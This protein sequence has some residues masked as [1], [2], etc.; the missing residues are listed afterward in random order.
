[1][2]LDPAKVVANPGENGLIMPS[3]IRKAES[4]ELIAKL[5]REQEGTREEVLR[6]IAQAESDVFITREKWGLRLVWDSEREEISKLVG[7][8]IE[9][10]DLQSPK[11]ELIIPEETILQIPENHSS[12]S[13]ETMTQKELEMYCNRYFSDPQARRYILSLF[14]REKDF[15]EQ[16]LQINL[17]N[18]YQQDETETE[19]NV[20]TLWTTELRDPIM[21]RIKRKLSWERKRIFEY[22]YSYN[23]VQKMHKNTFGNVFIMRLGKTILWQIGMRK[24]QIIDFPD[25]YIQRW[26][27]KNDEYSSKD[28]KLP[29]D[30]WELCERA[31][32]ALGIELSQQIENLEWFVWARQDIYVPDFLMPQLERLKELEILSGGKNLH[33]HIESLIATGISYNHPSLTRIHG[34]TLATKIKTSSIQE[35]PDISSLK[36]TQIPL[37]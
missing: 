22:G 4:R 24:S 20:H 27:E 16:N 31:F 5:S 6:I 26:E 12:I 34:E 18:L 8:K 29:H 14:M 35:Y 9:T 37:T 19:N 10:I 23:K 30:T 36:D 33:E 17:N 11:T 25:I 1:M 15:Q 32:I 2:V 7:E 28:I 21:L 13:P 3:E